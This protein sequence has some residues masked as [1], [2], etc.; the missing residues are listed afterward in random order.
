M[1]R[2]TFDIGM[3]S[4]VVCLGVAACLGGCFRALRTFPADA[5]G[6]EL[7]GTGGS[8]GG[9]PGDASDTTSDTN[10]TGCP[11]TCPGPATGGATGAGA[12][13]NGQCRISC[14][15]AYPTLCATSNACVDLTSDAKNCGTCGHDCLGGTCMEGQ[16]Q[17]VLIAQYFGH[18][19]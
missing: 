3:L 6:E 17:P 1:S 12:C 11:A 15:S 14:N 9:S 4:S 7:S 16:C 2:R 19:E 18:P 10:Q 5:G 13:V 8:G